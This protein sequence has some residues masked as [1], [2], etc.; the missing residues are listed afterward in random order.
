MSE[1]PYS[2]REQDTYREDV[3]ATLGRIEAQTIKT[4]GR[5]TALEARQDKSENWQS[6]MKGGLAVVTALLVP[7]LL[8]LA[9]RL[10]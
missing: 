6:F 2:K 4:N 9:A 1:A 7:V 8:M 3:L 10:L 5:V